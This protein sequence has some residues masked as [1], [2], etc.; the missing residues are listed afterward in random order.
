MRLSGQIAIGIIAGY[1]SW[2]AADDAGVARAS[3]PRVAVEFVES[4]PIRAALLRSLSADE[5]LIELPGELPHRIALDDVRS[6]RTN[7]TSLRSV[8]APGPDPPAYRVLLSS[9]DELPAESVALDAEQLAVVYGEPPVP[10]AIPLE[11]VR[12]VLLAAGDP[13]EDQRRLRH[14]LRGEVGADTLLLR[15]GDRWEGE[16]I[17]WDAAGCRLRTAAGEQTF[18]T[19][20]LTAVVFDPRS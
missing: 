18:T 3:H 15:S 6:L 9:G 7:P 12:A 16:L 5:L 8:S 10:M 11:F 2:A 4:A 17:G 14:V 20:V 19:D 1:L 13:E